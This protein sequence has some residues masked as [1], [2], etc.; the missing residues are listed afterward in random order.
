MCIVSTCTVPLPAV[1]SEAA[2]ELVNEMELNFHFTSVIS[3]RYSCLYE[4]LIERNYCLI[5]STA[6]Q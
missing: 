1:C 4:F 3:D 6:C 5:H 2:E